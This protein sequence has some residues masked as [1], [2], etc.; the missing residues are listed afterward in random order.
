MKLDI[1]CL[2][3]GLLAC[4]WWP[5][6][7]QGTAALACTTASSVQGFPV[8]HQYVVVCGSFSIY[9]LRSSKALCDF[10]IVSVDEDGDVEHRQASFSVPQENMT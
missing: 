1:F 5:S 2:T 8:L 6:P 3:L 4:H 9:S 7:Q 10:W